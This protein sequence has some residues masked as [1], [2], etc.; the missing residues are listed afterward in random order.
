MVMEDSRITQPASAAPTAAMSTQAITEGL[1]TG[2]QQQQQPSSEGGSDIASGSSQPHQIPASLSAPRLS[3]SGSPPAQTAHTAASSAPSSP[4]MTAMATANISLQVREATP[5]NEAD[6]A[7][8]ESSFPFSPLA[9]TGVTASGRMLQQRYPHVAR[10]ERSYSTASPVSNPY[11][12]TPS[13]SSAAIGPASNLLLDME[14]KIKRRSISTIGPLD[15]ISPPSKTLRSGEMEDLQ[16]LKTG[17]LVATKPPLSSASHHLHHRRHHHHHPHHRHRFGN[18]QHQQQVQHQQ[19]LP[20]YPYVDPSIT[21]M[22]GSKRSSSAS[23][24]GYRC[25]HMIAEENNDDSAKRP[26]E[27]GGGGGDP[28]A[29]E[30]AASFSGDE[31]Y[32]KV[33]RAHSNPEVEACPVCTARKECEILLKRTYSKVRRGTENSTTYAYRRHQ[34]RQTQDYDLRTLIMPLLRNDHVLISPPFS[35]PRGRGSGRIRTSADLEQGKACILFVSLSV[36]IPS[37]RNAS[38]GAERNFS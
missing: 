6:D 10:R 23:G 32:G 14:P 2:G 8:D 33:Q 37:P 3:P 34:T 5:S 29:S 1:E 9:A 20:R 4:P 21:A 35:A 28:E 15:S 22:V 11:M 16:H 36:F 24:A 25:H 38:P 18:G 7:D 17:G 13:S 27:A 12:A 31:S 19:S 30:A 26:G